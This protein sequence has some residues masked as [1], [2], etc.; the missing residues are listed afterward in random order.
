VDPTFW[1]SF[2][3]NAAKDAISKVIKK[4]N[5]IKNQILKLETGLSVYIPN[6]PSWNRFG[7][8]KMKRPLDSVI[9]DDGIKERLQADISTFISSKKWF[10]L[11]TKFSYF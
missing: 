6:G 11:F 9:L 4:I 2:L 10:I 7:N 5:S 3:E 8:P 1:K